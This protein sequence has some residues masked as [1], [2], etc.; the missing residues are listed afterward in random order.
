M[1][2]WVTACGRAGEAPRGLLSHS[3]LS[4]GGGGACH[5]VEPQT[6]TGSC[7]PEPREQAG[8]RGPPST[9]ELPRSVLA[10]V[11]AAMEG[12]SA[13]G[14]AG[15]LGFCAHSSVCRGRGLRGPGRACVWQTRFTDSLPCH[16]RS[17]GVRRR[18]PRVRL[19]PTSAPEFGPA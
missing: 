15:G 10:A 6:H 12:R 18:C 14:R 1:S 2:Q 16:Q 11:R 17:N 5:P 19:S 9:R 4:S 7:L 3:L 13:G 8:S